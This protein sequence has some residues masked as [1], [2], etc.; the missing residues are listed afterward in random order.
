MLWVTA[1]LYWLETGT[2]CFFVCTHFAST[3][4]SRCWQGPCWVHSNVW[5]Y[6]ERLKLLE[7]S[8]CQR[9][10]LVPCST[11]HERMLLSVF[12]S[13]RLRWSPAMKLCLLCHFLCLWLCQEWAVF[14]YLLFSLRSL[15][16]RYFLLFLLP[17]AKLL[18]GLLPDKLQASHNTIYSYFSA[19]EVKINPSS[20]LFACIPPTLSL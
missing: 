6:T 3:L 12:L 13:R 14:L 19:A 9:N 4:V 15:L 8:N 20:V 18:W 2:Q 17:V 1:C 10:H 16:P 11:W 7:L 5:L